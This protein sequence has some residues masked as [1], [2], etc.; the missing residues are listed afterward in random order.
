MLIIYEFYLLEIFKSH[1][2]LCL[3]LS[4]IKSVEMICKC[5]PSNEGTA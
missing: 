5:K 3:S 4:D 1:C 2:F